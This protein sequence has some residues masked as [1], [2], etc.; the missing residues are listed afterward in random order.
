MNLLPFHSKDLLGSHRGAQD[1]RC[2]LS[3]WHDSILDRQAIFAFDRC[4]GLGS[5]VSLHLL[6]MFN[7][8]DEAS[9]QLYLIITAPI[10]GL[11]FQCYGTTRKRKSKVSGHEDRTSMYSL[12]PKPIRT[13]DCHAFSAVSIARPLAHHIKTRY[14]SR[15]CRKHGIS[16][17]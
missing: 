17:K 11:D 7:P 14:S 15:L 13:R 5:F 6:Q 8:S 2:R 12:T 10:L 1:T 9:A 3:E 16:F 4:Q